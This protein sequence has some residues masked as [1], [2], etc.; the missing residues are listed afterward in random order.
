MNPRVSRSSA[1]ASKATGFPIAKIAAKLAVGYTLDEIP[2]DITK[3]TPASF[4]P[5]IDYVVTKIPRWAFEKLPGTPGMLGTQM[6]SVG[7][8]M[9]IGR[10]FPE[11]APEGPPVAR[12]GPAR[13][14]LRPGGRSLRREQTTSSC[15]RAIGDP[16]ARADLPD[17]RAAASRRVDRDDPRG[18]QVRPVVPRPDVDHHRGAGACSADDRPRRHDRRD[19]APRQ[20]ARA[21]PTPS[22]PTCGA[23]TRTTVRA[24]RE[25]AG[26]IPTYKTVDTCC[27]RVRGRDAVPLLDLRGRERGPPE[28]SAEGRH[29]RVGSEPDRPGH[30]VRLLLRPRQLRPARSRLRDDHDQLQPRDRLDRLRHER[31]AVLRAAHEGRRAQRHRR[32]AALQGD[33]VA[34]RADAAQA[35]RRDP[36]RTGRRYVGPVDRRRRGPREVEPALRRAEHPAASRWHRG[37]S[38]TGAR[39]HRRDRVPRPRAAELRARRTG[40]ADRPRP[41]PSG[42]GDGRAAAASAASARR[43]ASRP[44][45]RC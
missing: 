40:D 42:A 5:T 43:A 26:V 39:D 15:W 32:R 17:R 37:R 8:A 33:R 18:Q 28:R 30:R 9:S 41:Q 3:A 45:A 23:S 29:P 10:T 38:R 12:A 31:P 24:A 2:N 27:G 19:L 7:E 20:A 44:S 14:Q 36:G 13:T 1:L 11:I 25:A 22:S 6:Q 16:D 35:V 4:E 21:S 34:R